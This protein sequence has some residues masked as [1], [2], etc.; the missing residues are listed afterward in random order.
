MVG[1]NS[2]KLRQEYNVKEKSEKLGD[3][4]FD[5]CSN[6]F[7]F[8]KYVIDRQIDKQVIKEKLIKEKLKIKK[9]RLLFLENIVLMVNHLTRNNRTYRS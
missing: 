1:Y 8:L 2:V 6:E 3:V 9:E 7:N 4:E 5:T